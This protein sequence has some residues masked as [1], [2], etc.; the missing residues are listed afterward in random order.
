LAKVESRV[1]NPESRQE[2][3]ESRKERNIDLRL[4]EKSRRDYINA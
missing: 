1:Q 4:N 3:R 2:K